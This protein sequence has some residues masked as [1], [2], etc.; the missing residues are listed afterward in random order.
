[1]IGVTSSGPPARHRLKILLLAEEAA[2]LQ[3]LRAIVEGGYTVAA[4]MT[5]GADRPDR[6]SPIRDQAEQL[7]CPCWPARLVKEP[8]FAQRLRA[9]GVDLLVNVHSLFLLPDDVLSTPR[10]GGYNLHPG[11][12]PEYAGLNAVSWALYR[13]ETRHAVTVHG[14]VPEVDAGPIA[15]QASFDVEEQDTALSLSVK[16]SGRVFP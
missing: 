2:G 12:L 8:G 7:G 4:V 5:S 1:M 6:A 13:G 15:Y 9:A 14:M 11:P 10:L 16:W 3:M